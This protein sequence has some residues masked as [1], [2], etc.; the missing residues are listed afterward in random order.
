MINDS[1]L[2]AFDLTWQV[3]EKAFSVIPDEE[4]SKGE[5]EYLTPSR[6]IYHAIETAEWYSG[7]SRDFEWGHLTG[8]GPEDSTAE[9][10]PSK[11]K[12]LDYHE[13]VK[14][15]ITER[16]ESMS[17]EELLSEETVFKWTGSTK[18]SRFLYVLSH[19]RNHFGEI[20]AELRHRG[21]DR[22]KWT[23]F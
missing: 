15:R 18:L 14:K 3:Y 17:D 4:W 9:D 10:L 7:E 21:L 19:Y 5:I 2:E 16:L 22:V 11:E 8:T 23:T 13:L 12:L 6:I 20:N 1:L